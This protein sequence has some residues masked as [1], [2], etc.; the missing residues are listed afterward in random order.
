MCAA[1]L[2]ISPVRCGGV[3]IPGDAKVSFPRFVARLTR[4]ARLVMLRDG[5]VSS[6]RWLEVSTVMGTNAFG[7]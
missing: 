1:A 6:T 4:S 3:P 2:S 7:S 5:L